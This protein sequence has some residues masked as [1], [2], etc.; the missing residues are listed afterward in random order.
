[1]SGP[2]VA[3]AE[4]R[5][6]LPGRALAITVR[7]LASY[8]RYLPP[9]HDDRAG[10]GLR[11]APGTPAGRLLEE[12]PIPAGDRYTFFI[13]GRHAERDQVLQEGDVLSVFPAVGGG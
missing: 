11:V 9:D 1:M 13:N 2:D 7:L 12:L 8:R 4:A 10:Y 5:G 6:S 3:A